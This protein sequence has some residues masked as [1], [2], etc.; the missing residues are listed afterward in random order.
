MRK[1]IFRAGVAAGISLAS[2]PVWASCTSILS[3]YSSYVSSSN[4]SG[5][6]SIVS[7]Y[8]HC[9]GG[10][11]STAA[12]II[13][14]TSFFLAAAIFEAY[15]HRLTGV[16]PF[17]GGPRASLDST[18]MAAGATAGKWN[19][20]GNVGINDTRQ[21]Y[22]TVTAGIRAKNRMDVDTVVLGA[23]YGLSPNSVLGISGAF[24]DG[25]GSG[26]NTGVGVTPTPT[27][28]RGYMLAP[29]FSMQLSPHWAFDLSAGAGRGELDTPTTNASASRWFAAGNLSYM[30]WF[31][32]LQ[33]IGKAGYHHAVENYGD[34][35][36]TVLG[37]I[38]GSD[39]KNTLGQ[40]KLGAQVGYWM[41]GVM[42]VASLTYSNDI[43]RKTTQF[44]APSNP[45]GRDGW[46]LG[47]GLNFY[48]VKDGISGGVMYNQEFGRHNQNH[49]SLM[50]NINLRF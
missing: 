39:A 13:R 36:D 1:T 29:Y 24:D 23:D 30:R 45:I 46:L 10:S 18:G 47:L 41:N 2:V 17:R 6:Q 50:A 48:S 34:I 3:S 44:G 21:S 33:L 26:T 49:H 19:F 37:K 5:A 8:P 14:S 7:E 27:E 42:P 16:G 22:S 4:V 31:D 9:F 40:L 15:L 43:R 35:E 28:S 32:N 11:Q 38:V 20:W 12:M 25:D